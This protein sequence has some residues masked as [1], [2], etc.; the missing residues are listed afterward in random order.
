MAKDGKFGTYVTDGETNASLTRGDRLEH[1]SPERAFEL[2]AARRA[3]PP[4]P[5]TATKPK[6]PAKAKTTSKTKATSRSR[7]KTND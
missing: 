7:K 6:Q 4:Q 3:N 2:L 5:K 1:M